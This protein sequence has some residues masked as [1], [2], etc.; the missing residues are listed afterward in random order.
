MAEV[1]FEFN[2]V[3]CSKKKIDGQFGGLVQKICGITG[4][5]GLKGISSKIAEQREKNGGRCPGPEKCKTF[6]NLELLND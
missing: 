6:E 4:R 3:A 2:F 1:N 5:P